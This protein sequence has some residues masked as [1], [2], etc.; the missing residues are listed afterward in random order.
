MKGKVRPHRLYKKKS[1]KLYIK[2][3]NKKVVI[4]T[5]PSLSLK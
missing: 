5:S 4:N 3:G 1:G 2:K